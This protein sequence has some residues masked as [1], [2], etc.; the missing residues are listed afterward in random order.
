[1]WW[2]W[3]VLVIVVLLLVGAWLYSRRGPARAAAGGTGGAVAPG[4]TTGDYPGT[5]HTVGRP[6]E[7]GS[8]QDGPGEERGR[9]AS[10]PAAAGT[11]A[12]P[13]AAPGA[14]APE[15]EATADDDIEGGLPPESSP[16]PT[17]DP[18]VERQD[19]DDWGDPGT[20]GKPPD[21]PT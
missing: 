3:I 6:D 12:S 20:E 16:R 10:T 1:M 5:A 15:A 9:V 7:P 13:G 11:G 18:P 19:V 21:R 8:T 4:S 2:L 17:S 14:R